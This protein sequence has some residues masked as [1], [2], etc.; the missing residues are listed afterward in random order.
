MSAAGPRTTGISDERS[1]PRLS[2]PGSRQLR[3]AFVAGTGSFAPPRILTNQDLERMVETSD[4][5]ITTRTGIR[6]RRVADADHAASDLAAVAARGALE[7][8]EMTPGEL[9]LIIVATVTPD[10]LFPSAACTLQSKLGARNAAAFDM[11]AACSGFVYAL[12]VARSMIAARTHD[13]ILVVGVEVLSRIV[14]YSD[15]S[16]CVLFGDG[17]G[18]VVL[19]PCDDPNRGILSVAI[20]ADG[21]YGDILCMPAG[22]SRLPA[23]HE[24]VE[25]HLHHIHM[26]GNEIFKVAVRGMEQILR[27]AMRRAGVDQNG[28]D[29]LVPHQANL[30]IIDAMARR[31]EM[32]P[33]KV[34][35]NI[36]RYGNT[37][38]AS[39]PIGLD[40]AVRSGRIHRGD[41]IAMVT[42]GGGLTWG[43]AVMRW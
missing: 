8:A 30:R 26:N 38:S 22:G 17:A 13:N 4:E 2:D 19:K 41:T 25:Q 33:G 9:D 34:V 12:D 23:S 42:F 10:H 18:A 32:P 6:A 11:S 7:S 5:W 27:E 21:D 20:G 43:A 35:I 16:T 15:R 36:D 39:I 31:L 37:S 3:G 14:D 28:I 1:E 24:T 29:L 40:E